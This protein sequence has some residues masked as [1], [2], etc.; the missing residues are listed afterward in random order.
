MTGYEGMD[1]TGG[2]RV[3]VLSSTRDMVP[4]PPPS[5]HIVQRNHNLCFTQQRERRSKCHLRTVSVKLRKV[6]ETDAEH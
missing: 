5:M 6:N 3:T 1:W 2:L 4:P